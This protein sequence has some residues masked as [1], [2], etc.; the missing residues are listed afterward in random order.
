MRSRRAQGEKKRTRM[1]EEGFRGVA[2]RR[3]HRDSDR[4]DRLD[5]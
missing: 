3:E 1:D 5:V 2:A 4:A